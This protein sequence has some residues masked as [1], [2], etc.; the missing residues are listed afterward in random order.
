MC[1]M[2]AF[3][4]SCAEGVSSGELRGELHLASGQEAIAAGMLG[5]LR[6]EDWV[7]STHRSHLH[8]IAK[9]V[10][11]YPLMAEIFEKADGLAGGKGGHLH[12]FDPERRFSCTGMV[13]SSLPVAAGHAYA[14]RLDGSDAIAVGITGD[15]GVNSGQF[16]ETM[17][18][19]AIWGLP[20]VVLVENNGYAISVPA[21][22][23]V[24]GPGI[25]ERAAAYGAWGRRVDGTDV[26]AVAEAFGEAAARARG[27][28]LALLEATCSRF[29]GHYEGDPDHYRPEADRTAMRER[30][31]PIAIA[32]AR[33]VEVGVSE[34]ELDRLRDE[35]VAEVRAVRDRVAVSRAPDP[36]V[37]LTDVFAEGARS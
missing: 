12:L 2:R 9:G 17:N 25:A 36:S 19:A 3:E 29:R 15:G 35:A 14:A 4:E 24:A 32:R 10:P 26:E 13:A 23:V 28:G 31:D 6:P 20:L 37:A 22:E 21:A 5:T 34:S 11:L 18:M 30:T 33:L 1:L 27:S 7:A 8:A 16:H